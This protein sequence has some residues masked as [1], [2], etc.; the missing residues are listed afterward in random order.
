MRTVVINAA[1]KGWYSKGQKRL[2]ESLRDTGYT[3][4]V[5]TWD[6]EVINSHHSPAHPY[7]MKAAAWVEA[8]KKGYTHILWLDCSVYAIQDITPLF[9]LINRQGKYFWK[10]GWNLAQ[11]SAD[12][13]LQWAGI[14]RDEA[15]LLHECASGI[16]GMSIY[17][18]RIS[19]LIDLFLKANK[20]GICA[21]SRFHANQSSDPR[22][23]FARQDQTAMSLAFHKSGF[24]ND[25]MY[26]Q[27]IYSSFF[28]ESY[29]ESVYLVVQ[30]M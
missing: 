7:T 22:F 28:Q 16:V 6:N 11:S 3:G 23:R 12:S 15:E 19:T 26:E 14:T 5:L 29:N 13:D 18:P 24:T 1:W 27:N 20:A 2:V 21:T 4:D 8:I 30:G 17:A 9:E 10:S 25:Q